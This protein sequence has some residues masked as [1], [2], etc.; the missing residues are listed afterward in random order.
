[1]QIAALNE[2]EPLR[3]PCC[4][5]KRAP[6]RDAQYPT[7]ARTVMGAGAARS[8]TYLIRGDLPGS[9]LSGRL[10]GNNNDRP[11][12]LEKSD[13]LIVAWKPV[14]AGGAKGRMD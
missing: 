10:E 14:K 4:P 12:P 6:E 13:P 5:G 11:M 1:M 2:S 7:E 9:A 3:R 8:F